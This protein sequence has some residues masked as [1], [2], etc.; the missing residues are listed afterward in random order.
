MRGLLTNFIPRCFG[1]LASLFFLISCSSIDHTLH[2]DEKSAAASRPTYEQ[3]LKQNYKGAKARI[4]VIR[5]TD[6]SSGKEMSQVGD[7]IAEMLR[8][9]L[10]ATNRYIIQARKSLDEVNKNPEIRE[11][12]PANK[13]E[14]FDLLVEGVVKEFKHGIPGAG[15]ETGTSNVTVLVTVTDPR[16]NQLLA[17][18]KIK[19]KATDFAG[20]SGKR[21]GLPEA[22][23]DFSRTPMEKALYTVVEESAGFVVAKTP[24]EAYRA[25]PA[26]PKEAPKVTATPKVASP[27]PLPIT[28]VVWDSVNLRK[29][30]GTSYKIIGTVR[31]GTSLKI[32]DANGDWFR[33]R[34]EDGNTAW[35]SRLATSDAPKPSSSPSPSPSPSPAPI[36]PTPM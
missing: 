14:E 11:G 25:L 19:A 7:G 18:E 5:F 4:V 33:V 8:Y 9:S 30:P 31:R 24:P 2:P 16:T 29:G 3:I 23:K 35:V 6:K 21:G 32:L 17:T 13:E 1:Y 20:A 10:W 12:R 27:A 34:L 28:Q 15:D 22:F 36:Q 26:P